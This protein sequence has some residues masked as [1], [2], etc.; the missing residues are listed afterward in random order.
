MADLTEADRLIKAKD[1]VEADALLDAAIGRM[2]AYEADKSAANASELITRADAKRKTI[3]SKVQAIASANAATEAAR[4]PAPSINSWGGYPKAVKV[5][6]SEV[7]HDPD[8]LEFDGC[9]KPIANGEYWVSRCSYRG[10]NAFG[11]KV[12][13]S[14]VFYMQHDTVVKTAD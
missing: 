11:A 2:K 5:Y 13:N 8:T 10:N 1:V 14:T 6:L 9:T 4:G 12:L 3:E 7:M